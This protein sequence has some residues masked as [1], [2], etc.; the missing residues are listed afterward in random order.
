MTVFVLVIAMLING[1]VVTTQEVVED[2]P[3]YDIFNAAMDLEQIHG[4]FDAWSAACLQFN[5]EIF[6]K[7]A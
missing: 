4:K 7:K 6:G 2:C 1:E 5:L 3:N